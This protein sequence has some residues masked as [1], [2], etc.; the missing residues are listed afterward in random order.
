MQSRESRR[1][2][3]VESQAQ[4]N[5]PR[6]ADFTTERMIDGEP[7]LHQLPDEVILHVFTF[8]EPLE[9]L[10]CGKVCKLWYNLSRD[11]LRSVHEMS[12]Q[13]YHHQSYPFMYTQRDLLRLYGKAHCSS[14][15]H[16]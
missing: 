5:K 16:F 12:F 1:A 4:R 2:S 11:A 14:I 15:S 3:S 6:F 10:D 13:K 9:L 7:S 8:L